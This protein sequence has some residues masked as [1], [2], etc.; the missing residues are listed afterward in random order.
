MRL[1]ARVSSDQ[2]FLLVSAVIFAVSTTVTIA[3]CTS[4][5][6]IAMCAPG[7]TWFGSLAAFLGMWVVMMVAMMLPSL[8]PMLW[9]Y[10]QLI[11]QQGVLRRERLTLLVSAGYFFVWTAFGLFTY[12]VSIA[13]SAIEVQ[14]PAMAQVSPFLAGVI[15]L[16]AGIL[17]FSQWKAHHLDCSRQLPG[18]DHRVSADAVTAL[19]YGFQLGLHCSYC[20]LGLMSILLVIGVM[21]L[22]AMAVVTLA[23][24]FERLA[25]NAVRVA[26]AIGLVCVW[27]GVMTL[28][29]VADLM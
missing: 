22:R 3:L 1:N 11:G 23:M 18:C 10:R 17:Q 7:Q 16:F 13:L 6:T 2:I 14:L 5:S 8:T 12:I 15:I 28:A 19:R 4:M 29:R 20:C 27:A 24:T 9:R 21:D 25:P 26:Q